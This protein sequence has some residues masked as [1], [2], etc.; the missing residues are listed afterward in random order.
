MRASPHND[1][2]DVWT[3]KLRDGVTWSD[4][5]PMTADDVDFT[6]NLLLDD[7]TATLE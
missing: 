2:Q 7:K 5:V 6:I 1:A 4:G 3:L